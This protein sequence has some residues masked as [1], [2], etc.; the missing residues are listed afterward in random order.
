VH[1]EVVLQLPGHHEDCVEQLLNL[2]IPY[3]SVLKDLA[4]KVHMLLLD[5][6]SS[7][8]LF[9]GDDGADY[10]ISGYHRVAR[11]HWAVTGPGWAENLDIA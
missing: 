10:C 6:G 2:Q 3:L 1:Q 8:W 7:P 11:Y 5:F 9:N 4:D